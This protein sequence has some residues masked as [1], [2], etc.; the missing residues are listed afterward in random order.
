MFGTVL[1]GIAKHG[2]MLFVPSSCGQKLFAWLQL[3]IIVQFEEFQLSVL[4][5]AL[6]TIVPGCV[7]FIPKPWRLLVA[8]PK[9]GSILPLSV[10]TLTVTRPL[11]ATGT[12]VLPP[13]DAPPTICDGFV[14]N[15]PTAFESFAPCAICTPL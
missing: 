2:S 10:V 7:W 3:A 13:N 4:S 8:T 5:R 14:E 11:S 9:L 15:T 1:V 6:P 12:L